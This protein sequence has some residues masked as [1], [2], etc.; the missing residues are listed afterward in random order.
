MDS[1]EFAFVKIR[2]KLPDE[3]ESRLIERAVTDADFIAELEELPAD[4]RF[5]SAV[6]GAGQ[7]IRNDPYLGN[8]GYG[9]AIALANASRGEDPF[10][11]RTEFVQ[12]LRMA[13]ALSAPVTPEQGTEDDTP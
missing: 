4:F 13:Q 7:L 6:A 9:D 2:Y 10:G 8:F 5:A 3:D 11:Y 1:D 12:L